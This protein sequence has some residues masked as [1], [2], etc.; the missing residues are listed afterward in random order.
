MLPPC[1]AAAGF[2]K[3]GGPADRTA[4]SHSPSLAAAVGQCS[5]AARE[6]TV[7]QAHTA[8]GLTVALALLQAC[9][10]RAGGR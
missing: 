3:F 8:D 1:S 5:E 7:P 4:A 10:A 2:E 6:Q 9:G